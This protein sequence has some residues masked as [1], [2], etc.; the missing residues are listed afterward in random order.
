M[1]LQILLI[2]KWKTIVENLNDF[3]KGRTVIIVAHRLS[4]VK[5]ADQLIVLDSGKVVEIGKHDTLIMQKVH[6]LI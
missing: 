6:I 4:T 2:Q 3:Y 1:K 5:S